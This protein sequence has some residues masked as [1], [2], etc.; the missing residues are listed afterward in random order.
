[1][2]LAGA[3]GGRANSSKVRLEGL[4]KEANELTAIFAA[5]KLTATRGKSLRMQN[6]RMQN[7]E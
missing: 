5:S 6:E 4:L 3:A 1:M 2:L 7:E